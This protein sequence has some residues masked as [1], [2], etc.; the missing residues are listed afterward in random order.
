L[1]IGEISEP[2]QS[3][4]GYH[5]IQVLGHENRPLTAD[6]YQSA[7]DNAFNTWLSEQFT[8]A[9]ISVI[10]DYLNYVPDRPTL[11]EAFNDMFATETA[12]A[13]TYQA[14]Q[15]T[16]DAMLALTPSSTPLPATA[17]PPPPTATP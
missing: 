11:Q 3:Q 15:E 14:Q 17:T 8:A 5:I 12:V 4:Y 9:T 16:N 6:D 13:P 10:P 7:V 1:N 2:V